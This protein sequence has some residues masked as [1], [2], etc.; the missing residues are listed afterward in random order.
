MAQD[1]IDL[2]SLVILDDRY[3]EL[4]V[5]ELETGMRRSLFLQKINDCRS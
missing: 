3:V 2:L 4:L 1:Y 5:V